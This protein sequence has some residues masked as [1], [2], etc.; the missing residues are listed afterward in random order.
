MEDFELDI[1]LDDDESDEIEGETNSP[2]PTG[3]SPTLSSLLS[4][5]TEL[6]SC[7]DILCDNEFYRVCYII[8]LLLELFS[9]KKKTIFKV[10]VVENIDDKLLYAFFHLLSNNLSRYIIYVRV[11]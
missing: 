3:Q 4:T 1:D 6:D 11:T 5:C 9:Y 2:T 7:Y 8:I 10:F